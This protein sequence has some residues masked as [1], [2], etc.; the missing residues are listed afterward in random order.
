MS[1]FHIFPALLGLPRFI[2]MVAVRGTDG[3]GA[4][5]PIGPG[6]QHGGVD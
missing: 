1:G 4:S 2:P 5:I 3:Q 6:C